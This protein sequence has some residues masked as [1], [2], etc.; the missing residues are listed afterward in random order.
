MLEQAKWIWRAE[1]TGKDQYV[2]FAFDLPYTGGN[3]LI[4]LCADSDYH[5]TVNGKTV[6]FGQ[7]HDYEERTVFDEISLTEA[8]CRGQNR[9][10]I[11]VW[12]YGEASFVYSLGKAGLIFEVE[13]D[14]TPIIWS[15]ERIVSA[16]EPHYQSGYGKS[17]TPQLGFSFSYDATQTKPPLWGP[18]CVV[19]KPR[20]IGI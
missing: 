7:Y 20:P 4:R 12:Y 18:S 6:G 16:K 13:V 3:A 15:D 11:L 10:E 5:L 2:L 17:I 9:V 1:S 14:H 19:E 8:L